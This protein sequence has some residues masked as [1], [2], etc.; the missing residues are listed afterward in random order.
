MNGCEGGIKKKTKKL[1]TFMAI[2]FK[3][4]QKKNINRNKQYEII[5]GY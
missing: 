3:N 1:T 5:S 4:K 2:N